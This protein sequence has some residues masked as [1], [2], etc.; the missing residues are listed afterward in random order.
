M[1]KNIG[2]LMGGFSSEYEISIKSA[3]V[4]Y[5]TLK[6]DFNCHKILVERK[7]KLI[8]AKCFSDYQFFLGRKSKTQVKLLILKM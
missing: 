8:H 6:S 3:E 1:K 7:K 2:I 4:V 5:Q